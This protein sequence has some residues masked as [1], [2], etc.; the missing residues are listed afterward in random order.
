VILTQCGI[1]RVA[2]AKYSSLSNQVAKS[3]ATIINLAQEI[4]ASVPQLSGYLEQ[5]QSYSRKDYP[6]FPGIPSESAG[7]T[8]TSIPLSTHFLYDPSP[9]KHQK[10]N[11]ASHPPEIS[12]TDHDHD[13]PTPR[14]ESLCHMLYQLHSLSTITFLPTNLHQW[15][16]QRIRWM[17]ASADPVDLPQI[18]AMLKNRTE[19]GFPIPVDYQYVLRDFQ[20]EVRAP[21]PST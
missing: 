13:F 20:E 12:V 11:P 19:D 9:F 18:R 5:L 16:Q 17:E 14:P 21:C 8:S 6:D 15:M 2:R 10:S 1:L 7:K 4:C 3:E